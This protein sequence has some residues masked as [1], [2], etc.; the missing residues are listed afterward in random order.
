[1][2]TVD[3]SFYGSSCSSVPVKNHLIPSLGFPLNAVTLTSNWTRQVS[4]NRLD[5]TPID[6]RP[7]HL[8]LP[9]KD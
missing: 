3:D 6:S 1:M 9:L 8:R 5:C 4:C 2:S 7:L